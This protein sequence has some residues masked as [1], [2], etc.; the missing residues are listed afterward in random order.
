MIE[1]LR[2]RLDVQQLVGSNERPGNELSRWQRK[3]LRSRKSRSS[4]IKFRKEFR[5]SVTKKFE[6]DDALRSE[7]SNITPI[8]GTASASLA[9]EIDADPR[10]VSSVERSH[11]EHI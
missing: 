6:T 7:Q 9:E 11:N 4:S 3:A 5:R 2:T 1:N 8:E 10:S